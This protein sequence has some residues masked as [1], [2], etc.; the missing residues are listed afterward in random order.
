MLSFA[1]IVHYRYII[2]ECVW[3]YINRRKLKYSEKNLLSLYSPKVPN[4]LVCDQ[5]QAFAVRGSQLTT[6]TMKRTGK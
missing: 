4:G 2:N 1:E 6:R 3:N 5:I